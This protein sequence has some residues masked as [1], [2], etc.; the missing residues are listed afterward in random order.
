MSKPFSQGF[1]GDD[2]W[3]GPLL[4][5][6][7]LVHMSLQQN[8]FPPKSPQNFIL[9]RDDAI[10]WRDLNRSVSIYLA[11]EDF[12]KGPVLFLSRHMILNVNSIGLEMIKQ[13]GFLVPMVQVD[14]A[15]LKPT[16][17]SY[18]SWLSQPPQDAAC[19]AM[20]LNDQHGEFSPRADLATMASALKSSGFEYVKDFPTPRPGQHL[21][22]WKRNVASCNAGVASK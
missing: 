11:R 14:P 3:T 22:V 13:S 6:G 5:C 21:G 1:G 18:A 15:L 20:M 8:D 10:A 4:D 12:N 9:D 19:F 16:L 17:E 2:A 7:T